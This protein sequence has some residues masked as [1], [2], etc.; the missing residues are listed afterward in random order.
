MSTHRS[1]R[2][3]FSPQLIIKCHNLQPEALITDLN[4]TYDPNETT[5]SLV[6]LSIINALECKQIEL[7]CQQRFIKI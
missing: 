7:N 2:P 6:L 1:L 3:L 5:Q 4:I